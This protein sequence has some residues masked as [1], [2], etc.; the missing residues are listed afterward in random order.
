LANAN[1]NSAIGPIRPHR[2]LQTMHVAWSV[3]VCVSVGHTGEL[4]T[5]GWTDR[6]AVWAA[7]SSGSIESL[8]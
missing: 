5:N 8:L 6:D 7:D 4:C 3:S 1:Q 2:L